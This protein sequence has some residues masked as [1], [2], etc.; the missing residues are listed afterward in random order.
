MKS[1]SAEEITTAFSHGEDYGFA[2]WGR[3]IAPIVF[4]VDDDSLAVMKDAMTRTV[5]V[6]GGTLAETDAELGANF[7]WFFVRDWQELSGIP[8]L[9]QLI[10]NLSVLLERLQEEGAQQ[11]RSFTFDEDGAIKFCVTLFNM[12]GELVDIPIQVL[13]T[14]ETVQ[15]LALWSKEAFKDESPIAVIEQN[16]LCIVKPNFAS[17]IRAAYDPVLPNSAS[18][19]SHALRLAARAEKLFSEMEG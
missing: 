15:C 17:L 13:V 4:G 1:L 10:P 18:D 6:T 5:A 8:N 2:R 3:P 19:T 11:Y 9:E 12:S 16:G 14:G 7:M